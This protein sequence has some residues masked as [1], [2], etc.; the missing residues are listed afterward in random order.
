MMSNEEWNITDEIPAELFDETA[1]HIDHWA[2]LAT[3]D[4]LEYQNVNVGVIEND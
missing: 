2:L 4:E 1:Q 3:D